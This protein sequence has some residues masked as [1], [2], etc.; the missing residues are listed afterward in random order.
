MMD[1]ELDEQLRDHYAAFRRDHVQLREALLD[2]IAD[3]PLQPVF[4]QR[5]FTRRLVMRL[6]AAAIVLL[7]IGIT[8]FLITPGSTGT[9]W[10]EVVKAIGPIETIQYRTSASSNAGPSEMPMTT[11]NYVLSD[12]FMR[13]DSWDQKPEGAKAEKSGPPDST[14]V[15]RSDGNEGT[16]FFVEWEN[17]KPRSI[18]QYVAYQS[19]AVRMRN[20]PRPNSE[21]ISMWKALENLPPEAVLKRGSQ[22]INGQRLLRF[23]VI[24]PLSIPGVQGS[25]GF[26]NTFIW[27]NP[28]SKRPEMLEAGAMRWTDIRFNETLPEEKFAAP[29]VPDDLDAE[30]TWEFI[31]LA[32][33]WIEKD[34]AFR[35]LDPQGKAIVTKEDVVVQRQ[36]VAMGGFRPGAAPSRGPSAAGWLSPEGVT[37]LDRFMAR[38]PGA[39]MTIEIT[40]EPPIKRTV[41]GRLSRQ[42]GVGEGGGGAVIFNLPSL[43]SIKASTQPAP[44]MGVSP[45]GGSGLPGAARYGASPGG[46]F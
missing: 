1:L 46:E 21:V 17:G 34:F 28:Q 16:S 39:T 20:T 8:V 35:V 5:F 29:T 23:E 38:N 13:T 9:T 12:R 3:E 2:G 15:F 31:L 4:T 26:S 40:G 41:Y 19:P 25:Q 30:V 37:K 6:S 36:E 42:V 24:T 11:M 10:A 43:E 32:D 18:R 14:T 7:A 45:E 33:K 22:E 44:P 27:V